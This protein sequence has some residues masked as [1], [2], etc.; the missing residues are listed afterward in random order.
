MMNEDAVSKRS[1]EQLT[2]NDLRK[3]RDVGYCVL[4]DALFRLSGSTTGAFKDA[5]AVL[6]LCQGS[7]LHRLTGVRGIKDFDV[8]GFFRPVSGHRFPVRA[9]WEG[10]FGPSVHGR[11]PDDVKAG[12]SG[13][14]VD[15][16][17]R[18]VPMGQ[19]EDPRQAV[20]R[21]LA[22]GRKGTPLELAYR[23]V[24]VLWPDKWF[25]EIV[26]TLADAATKAPPMATQ[27]P[28]PGEERVK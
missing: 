14:K 6:C 15:V 9:R 11:H 8:W 3:V 7:A 5:L 1:F 13:R 28:L 26:W 18:D 19:N 4:N 16:L 17:G 25:G 24:I 10:D 21:Y 22:G 12:R 2:D 23:P 27:L 20:R